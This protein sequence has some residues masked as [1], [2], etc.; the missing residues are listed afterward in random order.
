MST[1][2]ISIQEHIQAT[3]KNLERLLDW[4][5]RLDS[6]F[7]IILGIDTAMLGVL[8]TFAPPLCL[9]SQLMTYFTILSVIFLGSTLLFVYL[10]SYPQT[11]GPKK[12]L[13][14]FGSIAKSSFSEYRQIFLNQNP[15]NYLND[16]LEQC[17]RNSE[18]IDLKFKRLKWAYRTLSIGVL[19]WAITVYLFNSIPPS[20]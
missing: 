5:S 7:P 13:L 12:S 11:K 17:H 18:I 3:E 14:Y 19:P 2:A 1:N 15:E 9:W 20:K 8:A 4:V 6:K 10:G 16:L